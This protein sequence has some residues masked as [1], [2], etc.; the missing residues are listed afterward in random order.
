MRWRIS[1]AETRGSSPSTRASPEVGSW[2]PRQILRS[3][4]AAA[5]VIVVLVEIVTVSRPL[6]NDV[7]VDPKPPVVEN[8]YRQIIIGDPVTM[9]YRHFLQNRGVVNCYETM[10]PPKKAAPYGDDTGRTNPEYPF[11]PN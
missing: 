3:V 8:E 5:A 11:R 6:L 10:N 1:S 9:T 4:A 7:F 2:N